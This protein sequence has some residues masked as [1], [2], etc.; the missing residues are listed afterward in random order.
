MKISF[1]KICFLISLA[2]GTQFFSYPVFAESFNKDLSISGV[3]VRAQENILKG[4]IVRIY[5]TVHNNSSYD[6]SGVVKFYDEK[7]ASYIGT[8]QPVS[9]LTNK[10]DDVFT[11]WHSEELGNHPISIRIAPW[12]AV[13]DNPDNNKVTKNIYVDIDTDGDGK[14]NNVD[15]DDDN[16]GVLDAQDAFSLDKMESKDTDHDGIGDNADPDDDNDGCLDTADVLPQ[17]PKECKDSDGDSIGDN[18]DTFPYDPKESKDSDHDGLGDNSD[19]LPLNHG[20]IPSIKVSD[21][22]LSTGKP[23][24]FSAINSTDP[25]GSVVKFDWDFG[26]GSKDTG[27]IVDHIYKKAGGHFVTLKI[28]DNSGESREQQMQV[29]VTGRWLLILLII[30]SLL[31]LILLLGLLIPN[32]RFHYS[33]MGLV[34]KDRNFKKEP[35]LR[36]HLPKKR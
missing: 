3:D 21:G 16:D 12:V 35:L 2:L 36:K 24:T 11:D 30:S 13:G 4:E 6:L 8:D 27:V 19:S 31:L 22:K 23:V 10:T 14:G 26:D 28:T 18:S 9:I 17:D 33:K 7:A 1:Y 5:V 20:P 15:T 29:S 32:S 34:R 25:D